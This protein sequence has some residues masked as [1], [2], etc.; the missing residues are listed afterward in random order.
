MKKFDPHYF[1]LKNVKNSVLLF[2]SF[3]VIVTLSTSC[4]G[5]RTNTPAPEIVTPEGTKV[6]NPKSGRYEFPTEVTGKMDTVEWTDAGS[7]AND[8]IESDPSQYLEKDS[9]EPDPNSEGNNGTAINEADYVVRF[10]NFQIQQFEH[11]VGT[12]TDIWITGGGVQSP[13]GL[14]TVQLQR[15][16]LDKEN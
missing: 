11:S 3:F 14:P 13:N 15:K 6:Y 4:G 16:I 8:P 10:N 5:G 12:K 1:T 9:N 7:S 2:L